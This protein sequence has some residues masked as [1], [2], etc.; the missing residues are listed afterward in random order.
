MT[1]KIYQTKFDA[2]IA[3]ANLK[4]T[5]GKFIDQTDNGW[6]VIRTR[7]RYCGAAKINSRCPLAKRDCGRP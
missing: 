5:A 4:D 3:Y 1:E 2:K 6:Y 7:C